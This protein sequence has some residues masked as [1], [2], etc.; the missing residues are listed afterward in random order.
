MPASPELASP[1]PPVA[2]PALE[3]GQANRDPSKSKLF[4]D[5]KLTYVPVPDSLLW[6]VPWANQREPRMSATLNNALRHGTTIDTAI[7]AEWGLFRL[8][9]D[10]PHEGFQFDMLAAVFTRFDD[11]AL[12]AADYRIGAPLTY[13]KDGWEAKV[14]YEHTSGHFGDKFIDHNPTFPRRSFTRDEIVS[15]LAY[16]FWDDQFRVY[17]QL[18]YAFGKRKPPGGDERYDVGLEWTYPLFAHFPVQPFVAIDLDF[19]PEQNYVTN[20]T[21]QVG[22][23]WAD[24]R[25]RRAVRLALDYYD[26][27]DPYGGFIRRNENWVGASLILD[28]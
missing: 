3:S 1:L 15:G 12:M 26:G 11:G 6:E 4:W 7:G 13:A 25:T 8:A 20:R 18:G 19:R 14:G 16:R 17:G 24:S 22:A 10:R 2:G 9:P 5:E 28:W 21:I 23:R 27:R